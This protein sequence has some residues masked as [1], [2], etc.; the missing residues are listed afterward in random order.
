MSISHCPPGGE[1][2]DGGN[3]V[4]RRRGDVNEERNVKDQQDGWWKMITNSSENTFLV[5]PLIQ[6][7]C[8]ITVTSN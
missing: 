8:V 3:E 7:C 2:G 6:G 4:E 1:E 5:M